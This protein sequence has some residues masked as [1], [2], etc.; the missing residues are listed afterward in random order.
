M[1]PKAKVKPGDAGASIAS[2]SL[3][4]NHKFLADINQKVQLIYNDR[5]FDGFSDKQALGIAEGG[6]MAI[7]K[8]LNQ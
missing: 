4:A 1:A 6:S 3:S 8:K 5:R 2:S 7:F